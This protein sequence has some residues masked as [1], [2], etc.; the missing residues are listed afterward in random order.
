MLEL[1]K[2]YDAAIRKQYPHRAYFF[3]Q[4][5]TP[6]IKGNGYRQTSGNC[7]INITALML[8]HMSSDT[9]MP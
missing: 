5:A 1:L 6:S 2:I 9:I 4:G 3:L 7:G 8:L